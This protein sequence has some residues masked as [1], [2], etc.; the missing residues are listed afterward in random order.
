MSRQGTYTASFLDTS[1]KLSPSPIAGTAGS[2]LCESTAMLFVGFLQKPRPDDEFYKIP[3][4][5]LYVS[6]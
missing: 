2:K 4:T 5:F 3:S 6:T 1:V